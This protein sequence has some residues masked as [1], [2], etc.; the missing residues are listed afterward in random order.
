[1]K[2]LAAALAVPL[3]AATP[4]Y[5]V[6]INVDFETPTS[7]ASIDRH[8]A[9]GTDSEGVAGADLGVTFGLD[10][11][12]LRNDAA[13]PYF[14]NAPSPLGVMTAVGGDSAMNVAL[15]FTTLALQYSSAAS[16]FN[17]VQL[18]SGLNGSGSLLAS[19]P[20]AANAQAGGCS[21]SRLCNF[22]GLSA[23]SFGI[24]RSVT[25]GNAAANAVFDNISVTVVP[26]PGSALLMALGVA[27]F[28][29]S[30]LRGHSR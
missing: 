10:A 28:A 19:L 15:G 11:L 14:S 26:E 20:L 16:I 13:G 25:F 24:A 23:A 4:A 21:D 7:F 22:S 29:G 8:Y 27:A 18:W 6:V 30:R 3:L 5:A 9:G 12:A 17:G 1:M 2:R